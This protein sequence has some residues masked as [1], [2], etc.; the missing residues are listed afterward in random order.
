[1]FSRI[2]ARLS[3]ANV[4][5]TLAMVFAMTGGAYAAKKYLITNT[6]QISPKVLKQLKGKAGANGAPG[7]AGPAGPQGNPG[8]AGKDGTNGTNGEK[9]AAGTNG[10]NGTNGVSVTSKTL[11]AGQGG[12]TEGGS[13]F[14][15]A[16]NKK[17]KACNGSPWT[18]GGTLPVGSTE[19]GS[20]SFGPLSEAAS[21]SKEAFVPVASFSIPL[22]AALDVSHV[23]YIKMGETAP[24]G[25]TG[26]TSEKP[27]AESGNLCVYATLEEQ[28]KGIQIENPGI[29]GEEGAGTTG[30]WLLF[31]LS[32]EAFGIGTWAVTG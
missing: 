8:A 5:A 22:A 9:G 13:E 17:T 26:G 14:T 24:T 11:N 4:V 16:E 28:V 6:K 3:Y 31:N 7:A 32:G 23:H 19:T 10:A 29:F 27:T 2:S 15:A 1:M 30:A 21:P 20:W 18:A 25:C 12:C